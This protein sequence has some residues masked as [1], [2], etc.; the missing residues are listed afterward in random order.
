MKLIL[1][2]LSGFARNLV[3]SFFV[4]LRVLGGEKMDS[5]LAYG[6]AKPSWE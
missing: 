1:C 2:E 4:V 3:V 5:R 6:M